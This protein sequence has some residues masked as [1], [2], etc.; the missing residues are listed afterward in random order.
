MSFTLGTLVS[1]NPQNSATFSIYPRNQV[2]KQETYQK[3]F[4]GHRTHALLDRLD[5]FV[6]D[7]NAARSSQV[8]A[9]FSGE[10]LD[11]DTAQDNELRFDAV[12]DAVV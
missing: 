11:H 4:G 3:D 9:R 2:S 5:V 10:I 12:E 1:C 6:A 8:P 7:S